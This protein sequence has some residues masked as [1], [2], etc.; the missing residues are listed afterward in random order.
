MASSKDQLVFPNSVEEQPS[1]Q[2]NCPSSCNSVATDSRS[3][4][5]E[6]DPDKQK[7]ILQ[8]AQRLCEALELADAA[9]EEFAHCAHAIDRN[10]EVTRTLK[11]L[12]ASNLL[13]TC[14]ETYIEDV[15]V[16]SPRKHVP[17]A[18]DGKSFENSLE[19]IAETRLAPS[20]IRRMGEGTKA[21]AAD[22]PVPA[23]KAGR[24]LLDRCKAQDIP[25]TL[26]VQGINEL[27]IDTIG[28]L[29][30]H[31]R[32]FGG[33]EVVTEPTLESLSSLALVVMQST[34]GVEKALGAG[35]QQLIKNV[36]ISI[37]DITSFLSTCVPKA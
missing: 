20:M 19:F 14:A 27:G 25:R 7:N 17:A 8:V 24:E 5:P 4:L 26:V 29:R 37:S 2:T 33:V 9:A 6:V 13:K 15:S 28:C 31:F 21:R 18:G 30:R 35:S 32:G 11:F 36:T 10:E 3:S 16:D 1:F 12:T 23:T 34:A 22:V